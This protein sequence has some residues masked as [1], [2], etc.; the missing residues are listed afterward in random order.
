MGIVIRSRDKHGK[1]RCQITGKLEADEKPWIVNGEVNLWKH[2]PGRKGHEIKNK[3]GNI[4]SNR[5][6]MRRDGDNVLE[7]VE[8]L[9]GRDGGMSWDWEPAWRGKSYGSKPV[10]YGDGEHGLVGRKKKRPEVHAIGGE[11]NLARKACVSNITNNNTC[12][13]C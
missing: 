3:C 11:N 12:F 5:R 4:A 2:D 7:G 1:I 6:A 9:R 13:A 10:L 8:V